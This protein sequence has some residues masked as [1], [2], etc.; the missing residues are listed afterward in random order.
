MSEATTA[1]AAYAQNEKGEFLCPDCNKPYG[2]TRA[3][4]RHLT[5]KHGGTPSKSA[6]RRRELKQQMEAAGGSPGQ[7][8]P[9]D[10]DTVSFQVRSELRELALP[11]RDKVA[12]IDRRLVELDREVRDLREAKNQIERTLRGLEGSPAGASA[13]TTAAAN[14][15]YAKKLEA[16]KRHLER[17][18]TELKGGFTANSLVDSMRAAGVTPALSSQ[19]AARIIVDL[20]DQGIVRLD[21]ISRGGG[22][23][24]LLVSRN[25]DKGE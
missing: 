19:V 7:N 10:I 6:Q 20:R 16:V 25:G 3:L 11:L 9:P 15:G 4:K 21:R 8:E 18:P 1:E 14:I 12:T 2:T 22:Q 17:M 5:E 24:F 23:S 13:G